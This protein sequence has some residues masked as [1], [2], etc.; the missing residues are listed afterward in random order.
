MW[1]DKNRR[2][3]R[4]DKKEFNPIAVDLKKDK[5]VLFPYCFEAM[6]EQALNYAKIQFNKALMVFSYF[7][8]FFYRPLTLLKKVI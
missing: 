4:M 8:I 7:Q 6:S 2:S 3:D 1:Y 5:F